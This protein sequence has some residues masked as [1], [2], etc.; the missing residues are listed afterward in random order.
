MPAARGSLERD[1]I[2]APADLHANLKS[3]RAEK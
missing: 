3:E 1:G 2:T